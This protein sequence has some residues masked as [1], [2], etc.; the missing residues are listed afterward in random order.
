MSFAHLKIDSPDLS[1]QTNITHN[2]SIPK[3]ARPI[4]EG[5]PKPPRKNA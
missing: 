1:T 3:M 4:T 5:K 2:A